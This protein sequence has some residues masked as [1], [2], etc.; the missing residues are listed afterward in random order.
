[1]ACADQRGSLASLLGGD[2]GVP[3]LGAIPRRDDNAPTGSQFA[4]SVRAMDKNRRERE[5]LKQLL[6]GN[7]PDFLRKLRSVTVS[8]KRGNTTHKGTLWVM[9][10]YLAIGTDDDFIRMPM[11]PMTA[12]LIADHYGFVLPTSKLV[13]D[14]YKAANV[15]LDPKPLKPGPEMETVPYFERHHEIIEGQ[16]S[17]SGDHGKLLAG[18]KKD[19]VL[20]N[21]LFRRPYQVAIYG[22]HR[23]NGRP[24]QPVSLVHP[25]YYVDYSHGVRLVSAMMLLNGKETPVK[26]VYQDPVT[27]ALVSSEG[28]I[29]YIRFVTEFSRGYISYDDSQQSK[30]R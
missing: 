11:T 22:W 4:A 1:M 9:P 24:I 12:Q 25:N 3:Y 27:A 8:V 13:D 6:R 19:L 7:I 2:Y 20:T 26:E 14:I 23:K 28:P 5:V 16:L 10:D 30:L 18:H 15:K 29:R 21:E 17:G